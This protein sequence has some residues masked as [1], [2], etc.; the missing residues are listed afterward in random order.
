[1]VAL[2]LFYQPWVSASLNTAGD[3]TLTG[4]DL[5]R[6]EANRRVDRAVFGTRVPGASTG[7]S[8][9]AATGAI[10]GSGGLT[11]PT[12]VPTIAA[13]GTAGFGTSPGVVAQPTAVP[14]A[15]AAQAAAPVSG[16]GGLV[17]PTRVPTVAPGGTSGFGSS[18][19]V[20]S[21]P[22]AAAAATAAAAGRISG[23]AV[24]PKDPVAP[25][26]LP[27]FWL[28]LVPLAAL[29][30]AT[31]PVIW[32]R[33]TETRDRRFGRIWTL[34]LAY[35]GALGLG[36]VVYLVAT[37][38]T[39]NLLMGQSVGAVKSG[40]PA[41]W[42]TFI[43]FVLSALLLTVAWFLTP[44]PPMPDPYWRARRPDAAMA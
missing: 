23:A 8:S 19:G 44:T 41:L 32:D 40:E 29:G 17:L 15:P 26:T 6:G 2:V 12:R 39:G 20:A 3:S 31:F 13:G 4:I 7:G 38:G 18:A 21:Q 42:G 24:E 10:S 5:A 27:K 34:L 37:A 9:G 28:H 1:L 11:L 16:S 36:R 33:L 35:G 43:A 22:T 30:L 14:A 25:P